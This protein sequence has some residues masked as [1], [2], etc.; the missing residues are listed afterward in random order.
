MSLA[1][2]SLAASPPQ[3]DVVRKIVPDAEKIKRVP[4]R[5]SPAAREK[6][7]KA[8]GEKLDPADL[9]PVVWEAY[10][11]VPSVSSMD[12]T[13]VRVVV[14]TAKGPRG[15]VRVGVAAATL[16]NTV[17]AVKI[18]D[19][20]D[21][22]ALES[23]DFLGQFAGFEYTPN[24]YSG[25]AVLSTALRKASDGKDEAAKELDAVIR[26]SVLMRAVGPAYERLLDH[27]EKKDRGAADEVAEL[28]HVFEESIRLLPAAKFLRPTQ[29]E[30]FKGFAQEGRADLAELRGLLDGGRFEDA[31]RKAGRLEADRCSRCHGAYRRTFREARLEREVGNGH[32]STKVDV[33]VPEKAHE[34]SYQAVAA[35]VKKALLIAAE[36]R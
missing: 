29:V 7:E 13:L 24:L 30:K 15:P 35:G 6:I 4:R 14:A 26:M 17:H 25:P 34:A 32:F 2:L 12:K 10:A 19:N 18:L 27:L 36:A 1:F 33:A 16:E 28:D 5:I 22:K 9:A 23:R 31:Y 8:L 20:A 11:T 21:V 3:E